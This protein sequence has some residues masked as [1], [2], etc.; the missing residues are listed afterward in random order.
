V[1]ENKENRTMSTYTAKSLYDKL[2]DYDDPFSIRVYDDEVGAVI[3]LAAPPAALAA[4]IREIDTNCGVTESYDAG[5]AIRD[6]A[7]QE[8]TVAVL[9]KS[10]YGDPGNYLADWIGNA[11][12]I[13]SETVEQIAAE[14]DAGWE[15][16]D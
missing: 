8:L 1:Q 9:A 7:I 2:T 15:E 16:D 5:S 14:W 6:I 13:G 10:K 12:Y 4:V 3:V 11:T